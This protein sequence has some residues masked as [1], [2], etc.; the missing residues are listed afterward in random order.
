[1]SVRIERGLVIV[2]SVAMAACANGS[3]SPAASTGHAP[4]SPSGSPASVAGGGP[5][6]PCYAG[7]HAVRSI[8]GHQPVDTPAGAATP[9]GSGGSLVLE[10]RTDGR[11]ALTSD[12]SAPAA[13][14]VGPYAATAGIKGSLSG[15]Y[16]AAGTQL[17]FHQD[18]ATGS[19]VLRSA[20]GATNFPMSSL[21]PALVPGGSATIGCAADAIRLE[22]ASVAMELAP[23]PGAATQPV[24]PPA[25]A[26]SAPPPATAAPAPPAAG[27]LV[28]HQ[29][30]GERTD[31]CGGRTVAIQGSTNRIHLTG[32][33]P[34]VEI[35]GSSNTVDVERVD[36]ITITGSY[37]RVTWRAAITRVEPAVSTRGVG[38]DVA[39]G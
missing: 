31:A 12:G 5:A 34:R 36:Q 37:D 18:A 35:V 30:G 21:G 20:A 32:D 27:Q 24:P 6:G 38:D 28:I 14:Q 2:L 8:T 10:L 1:M 7:T 22:S 15:G 39:R 3:S 23:A 19:V 13:F 11:W 4:A 26:A 16:Q 29:S 17:A 33:C 9:A 25:T